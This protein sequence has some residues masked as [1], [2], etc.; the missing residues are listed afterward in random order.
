MPY[1]RR[2]LSVFDNSF[3]EI[4]DYLNEIAPNVSMRFFNELNQQIKSTTDFSFLYPVYEHDERFRRMP[5]R[6]WK[7]NV[8]YIV[9]E[10]KQEIVFYDILHMSRDI[11]TYLKER[12]K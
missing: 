9:D 12:F 10:A 5:M 1:K 4:V 7:Y 6:D 2:S 11:Q 8:F 3:S